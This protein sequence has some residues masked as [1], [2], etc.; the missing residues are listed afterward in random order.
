MSRQSDRE[1]GGTKFSVRHRTEFH[2]SNW[3]TGN[4]NTVH[5]EPRD[6]LFQK[7]L[8]SV[9]KV[10]PPTRLSRSTDLFG[11]ITHTYEIGTQ[12][13]RMVVESQIRV[14]NLPLHISSEGYS[15]GMEFYASPEITDRCRIYLQESPWVSLGTEIWKA[16]VDVT[17]SEDA[18]F[19]K[20]AAIMRWIY[21][22]FAYQAGITDAETRLETA[23]SLRKGVC[24]DFAHVMLGMCRTLGIPARYASGYIYTGGKNE[25]IGAQASHAWC[26]VYLPETGWIGFD[27]TNAVLADDRY[28]KVAVGRD[29]G[30]VAPVRGTFRGIA[31]CR[32]E[33]EVSVERV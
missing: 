29:Y 32:M 30:D 4:A 15:G 2:Y 25:L 7:T 9:V 24:Q 6:F 5:L 31:N 27:P 19:G 33:V 3:I 20:A 26:E 12:H 11:N 22:A 14:V 8:G 10:L 16:A 17:R 1:S 21:T 28:I 13:K 18:V 23:F